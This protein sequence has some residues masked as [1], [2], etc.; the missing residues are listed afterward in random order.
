MKMR[1]TT[2]KQCSQNYYVDGCYMRAKNWSR[3][4]VDDACTKLSEL[5]AANVLSGY[6]NRPA[7]DKL[8]RK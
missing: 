7:V 6:E 5:A 4:Q 1:R 3:A 2:L 8:P